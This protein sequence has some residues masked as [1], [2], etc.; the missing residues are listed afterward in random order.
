MKCPSPVTVKDDRPWTSEKTIRVPCGKC[1]ACKGNR[2]A[3]WS[4]RL[5]Q[6]FKVA[7]TGFFIT[8]TYDDEHL[9]WTHKLF[10]NIEKSETIPTLDKD[11]LTKFHKRIRK[12][13]NKFTTQKYRYYAVG[14][15]GTKTGR[16][17]YHIL[18]FNLAEEA[19]ERL[20]KYWTLGQCHI[21]AVEKA[22]IHYVTKFHVNA[23]K[24]DFVDQ[25]T[26]QAYQRIAEFATMSRGSGKYGDPY[27]YGIGNN[28]VDTTKKYHRSTENAFVVNNG[29]KQRLPRYYKEKLFTPVE[30]YD[31]AQKWQDEG[32]RNYWRE[33]DRLKRLGI[34]DPDH[35]MQVAQYEDAKRVK[36]KLK[37]GTI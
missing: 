21:G 13:N 29:F 18:A 4:F 17:H 25:E 26:G 32:D 19:V 1:G 27:R 8:L 24:E 22:S 2:R 30:R 35:Y 5:A 33:Y 37:P 10:D 36:N 9:P 6:E 11:D 3:D 12:A 20:P 34:E 7:S 15:Y 28:Y 16:P 31:M 14:E 23:T